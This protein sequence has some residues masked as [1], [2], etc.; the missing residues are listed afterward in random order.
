MRPT[1]STAR[2]ITNETGEFEGFGFSGH[3]NGHHLSGAHKH[4]LL[5]KKRAA[6]QGMTKAKL[7]DAELAIAGAQGTL[8]VASP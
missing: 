4:G 5:D 7:F 2:V 8:G 6:L 3:K 1:T